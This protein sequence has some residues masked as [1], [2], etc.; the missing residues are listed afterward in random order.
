[1][2]V[3]RCVIAKDVQWPHHRDTCRCSMWPVKAGLAERHT[4]I[5]RE[6]AQ[7]LYV[8]PMLPPKGTALD[9]QELE[10]MQ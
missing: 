9:R 4:L 3:W 10:H 7:M 2:A 5:I 6:D 8:L 1:M